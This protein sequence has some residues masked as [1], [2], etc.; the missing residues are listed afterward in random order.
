MAK[1]VQVINAM[2]TNE[3]DISNV[4]EN[5]EEYYFLY[6]QSHKWSIRKKPEDDE[7]GYSIHYYPDKD[8]TLEGLASTKDWLSKKYVTYKSQDIKTREADETFRELYQLVSNKIYGIDDI[9][10]EIIKG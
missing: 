7:D 4:I 1:I 6:N 2:I 10:N 3:K 9:F 5:N 8:D